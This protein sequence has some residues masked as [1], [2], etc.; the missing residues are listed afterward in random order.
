MKDEFEKAFLI[1]FTIGGVL[2]W[3]FSTIY[4]PL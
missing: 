1:S 4:M 2:A 3:V